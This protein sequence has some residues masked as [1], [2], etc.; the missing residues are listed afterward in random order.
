MNESKVTQLMLV[1]YVKGRI[2][3]INYIQIPVILIKFILDRAYFLMVS[4]SFVIICF[5]IV[6][7]FMISTRLLSI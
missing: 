3:Q 4:M 7:C 6:I 1:G 2:R 5:I